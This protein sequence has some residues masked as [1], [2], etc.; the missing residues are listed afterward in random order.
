MV[1]GRLDYVSLQLWPTAGITTLTARALQLQFNVKYKLATGQMTAEKKVRLNYISDHEVIRVAIVCRCNLVS[2]RS[3]LLD[4]WRPIRPS[5][6]S[7]L[8]HEY[9]KKT[10][11]LFAHAHSCE[12]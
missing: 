6:T 8:L 1:N 7:E 2:A 11:H 9:S 4:K 12:Y 5:L 10:S 3:W